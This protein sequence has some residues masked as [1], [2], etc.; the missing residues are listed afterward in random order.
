MP[1]LLIC[2]D[3]VAFSVL[4]RRWMRDCDVEVIGHAKTAEEAVAMAG[5]HRPAVIVVDH[6][7]PDA[8]SDELVPRLREAAPDARVLLISSLPGPDLEEAAAAID[9]DGHV[10]KAVSATEMCRAVSALLG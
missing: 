10:S 2:D 7:M 6:L 3:A 9:A 8:S 4:F 1:G 5:E